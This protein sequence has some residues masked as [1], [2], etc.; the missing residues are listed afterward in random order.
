MLLFLEITNIEAYPNNTV[1]IFNRWGV[2]VFE[3]NGYDNTGNV[4]TGVS[5][6]RATLTQGEKL[7]VGVYFYTIRYLNESNKQVSKSGYLYINR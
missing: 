4:F 3:T 2:K 7:P 1:Q 5:N 6:G